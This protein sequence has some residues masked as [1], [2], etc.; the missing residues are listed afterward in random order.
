M[1]LVSAC[2][3]V[4]ALDVAGQTGCVCGLSN[5]LNEGPLV[6]DIVELARGKAS[7]ERF[8]RA[9][10]IASVCRCQAQGMR[11]IESEGRYMQ[12]NCLSIGPDAG[13]LLTSDVLY[14]L[15]ENFRDNERVLSR[16]WIRVVSPL[17]LVGKVGADRNKECSLLSVA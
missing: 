4:H 17:A 2:D 6:F 5:V 16:V 12:F 8:V 10:A 14:N 13:S 7:I 1:C 11:N 15:I 3:D 9:F